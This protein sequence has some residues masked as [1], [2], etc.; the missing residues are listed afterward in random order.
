MSIKVKVIGVEDFVLKQK[1][2]VTIL[3]KTEIEKL[4]KETA[5][6]MKQKVTD[7]IQ[8]PGSTGNLADSINAEKISEL[9]WG[10]GNISYLN[11]HAKYWRWIN[12]GVAGTGRTT[13][14]TSI[15]F[16]SPGQS[17]PSRSA[18]GQGRFTQ[19]S[20]ADGGFLMIPTKPISAHNY[21]EKTLTEIPNIILRVLG[22]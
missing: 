1:E 10:I 7:S 13:P 20:G 16:F 5:N 21:I 18:F 17:A 3:A 19:S 8:R 2:F 4:A 22:K 12:Y 6:V 14:P 11:T 9:S 15:G